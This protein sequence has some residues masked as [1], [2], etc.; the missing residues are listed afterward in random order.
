MSAQ[1]TISSNILNDW[2]CAVC[3][4]RN[5]RQA[6]LCPI[7]HIGNHAR[8][9]RQ[10]HMVGEAE[11]VS[12]P[13]WGAPFWQCPSCSYINENML[14]NLCRGCGVRRDAARNAGGGV[15]SKKSLKKKYKLLRHKS[16]KK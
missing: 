10:W 9:L 8:K 14:C 7:C 16:S 1:N 4:N 2:V 5:N 13:R 11:A 6:E 12:G 15:F 3:S